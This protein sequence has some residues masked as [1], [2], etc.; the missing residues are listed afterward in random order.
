MHTKKLNVK[1]S[2]KI[3]KKQIQII[4]SEKIQ[5][6]EIQLIKCNKNII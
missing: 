1:N 6:L 4:L 3:W 2:T 5:P